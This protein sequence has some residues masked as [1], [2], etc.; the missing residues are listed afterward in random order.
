MSHFDLRAVKKT[1]VI[2]HVGRSGSFLLHNL[3]DGHPS[4]I[5]HPPETLTSLEISIHK[6]FEV[7][8]KYCVAATPA[9]NQNPENSEKSGVGLKIPE[10]SYSALIR[11]IIMGV[12]GIFKELNKLSEMAPTDFIYIDSSREIGVE[13]KRFSSA[14]EMIIK[15]HMENYK[16]LLPSDLF[17][18]V[19]YCYY[20]A[21]NEGDI[22]DAPVILWQKHG[23]SYGDIA[24]VV[25]DPIFIRTIRRPE[26]SLD[27]WVV[28]YM[29]RWSEPSH[30]IKYYVKSHKNEQDCYESCVKYVAKAML[31]FPWYG[32]QYAV[33][34]EDMHKHT[35]VILRRVCEIVGIS[36]H[37]ILLE[38]TLDGQKVSFIHW[39]GSKINKV[40]TGVNK[41][42]KPTTDF[43]F[44]GLDDIKQIQIFFK[45]FYKKYDYE[46]KV[47]LNNISRENCLFDLGQLK[48]ELYLMKTGIFPEL[49]NS[50]H[51][52]VARSS[53]A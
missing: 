3:L 16:V 17:A 9:S 5:S 24:A 43:K 6:I 31:L 23:G 1:V 53:V 48:N 21:S 36:W 42:L 29:D 19:F 15:Q 2:T 39:R 46:I 51:R 10:T 28:S 47:P 35:E 7:Y 4:I 49:I 27:A 37:P 44:I 25:K 26:E 20:K 50:K 12:P 40:V 22:P 38:T 18:L 8:G 52:K 14:A 32:P 11:D 33:R 45:R 30:A 13:I 41:N 34:F